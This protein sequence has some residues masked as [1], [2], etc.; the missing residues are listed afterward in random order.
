[1][2]SNNNNSNSNIT[3][4]LKNRIEVYRKSLLDLSANNPLINSRI[5]T[6]GLYE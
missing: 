1:M 3:D 2:A 5:T 4:I 6:R